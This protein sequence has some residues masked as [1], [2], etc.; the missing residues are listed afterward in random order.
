[1]AG[2]IAAQNDKRQ[3]Q[4][5]D[6]WYFNNITEAELEILGVM[7]DNPEFHP[8]GVIVGVLQKKCG[9]FSYSAR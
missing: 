3:A 1:M 4:C 9:S 5:I 7:K 8:R 2:L 6:D